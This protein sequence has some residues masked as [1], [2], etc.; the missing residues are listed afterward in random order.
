MPARD[1]RRAPVA[2]RGPIYRSLYVQVL[3]GIVLAVI[4]GNFYPWATGSSS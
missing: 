3:F 2:A 1:G 4:L